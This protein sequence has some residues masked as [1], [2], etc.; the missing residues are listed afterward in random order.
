MDQ[1]DYKVLPRLI[2]SISAWQMLGV[3]MVKTLTNS[4][5]TTAVKGTASSQAPKVNSG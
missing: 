4:S 5:E 1:N 3:D 2:C